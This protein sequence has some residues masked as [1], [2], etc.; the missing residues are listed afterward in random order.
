MFDKKD[1]RK[2][3]VPQC[4]RISSKNNLSFDDIGLLMN[5]YYKLFGRYEL[6]YPADCLTFTWCAWKELKNVRTI[7]VSNDIKLTVGLYKK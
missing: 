2:G 3:E 7:K 4:L 5:D 1:L 6:S